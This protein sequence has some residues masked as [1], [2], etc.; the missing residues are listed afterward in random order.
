MAVCDGYDPDCYGCRL[1]SKGVAISPAATPSRRN[2][3]APP[4]ADPAW[5]RGVAGER[6]PDG[7]FMPYLNDKGSRLHL[8]EAGERRREIAAVC[9][10]G[11][12]AQ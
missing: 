4:T 2:T 9:V 3:V 5:E 6:R 11:L 10:D 1:R 7:S 8:K 12:C